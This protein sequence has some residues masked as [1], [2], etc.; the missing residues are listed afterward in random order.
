MYPASKSKPPKGCFNPRSHQPA[1]DVSSLVGE[2]IWP[3]L[4]P[5]IAMDLCVAQHL[6]TRCYQANDLQ[7]VSQAW[8]ACLLPIGQ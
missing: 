7:R 6:V 1:L 3:S 4:S 8:K 2:R 5:T